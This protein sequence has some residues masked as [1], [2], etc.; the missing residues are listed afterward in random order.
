MRIIRIGRASL[1]YTRAVIAAAT[2]LLLIAGVVIQRSAWA[3]F[4]HSVDA[5]LLGLALGFGACVVL[6]VFV[7][8]LP[9]AK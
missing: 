4:P 8:L 2:A 7:P 5:T 3:L 6:R 1:S 9:G